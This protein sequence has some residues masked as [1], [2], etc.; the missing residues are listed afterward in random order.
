MKGESRFST[1]YTYIR[2]QR[3]QFTSVIIIII[4][5]FFALAI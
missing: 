1:V 5:C 3:T 2:T 4:L